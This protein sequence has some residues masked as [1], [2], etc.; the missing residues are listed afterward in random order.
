[1]MD[2]NIDIT[3]TEKSEKEDV[4]EEKTKTTGKTYS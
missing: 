2:N 3:T 4:S 1:M